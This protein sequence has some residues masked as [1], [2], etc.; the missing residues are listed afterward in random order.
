MKSM[1]KMSTKYYYGFIL[2]ILLLLF[3]FPSYAEQKDIGI[4]GGADG[5]TS[6]LVSGHNLVNLI[7]SQLP[8]APFTDMNDDQISSV[9]DK[10]GPWI[11]DAYRFVGRIMDNG[12]HG[13]LIGICIRETSPFLGTGMQSVCSNGVEYYEIVRN[14]ENQTVLHRY[15]DVYMTYHPEQPEVIYLSFRLEDAPQYAPI[16]HLLLDGR[17]T[18]L[19][20]AAIRGVSVTR[21]AAPYLDVT[22]YRNGVYCH[23]Y[24][25]LTED[26]LFRAA[27]SSYLYTP[28]EIGD[29]AIRLIRV[30][31]DPNV[32]T[33]DLIPAP[34]VELAREKCGFDFFTPK[35]IGHVVFASLTLN[36]PHGISTQDVTDP[37]Q[38]AKLEKILKAA[39]PS[40]MGG[41]PY[42]GVLTLTMEDGSTLTL[43]KATDSCD[44]ILFGSM[45][46]YEIGKKDNDVF[47]EIFADS[48][49]IMHE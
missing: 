46:H 17:H 10:L 14:D 30:G 15:A 33:N 41:C 13:Y 27:A 22:L 38:L 35:A 31:D 34:L 28:E 47:W 42:T 1:R 20:N 36:T 24:I 40:M 18:D 43:Q 11:T 5:P 6:I 4:I 16:F 3:V 39:K 12:Q 23:E 21:P 32:Y 26:D 2:F 37:Q 44:G 29:Y 48:Y 45:C 8:G 9:T 19:A 49:A 7:E 25:P